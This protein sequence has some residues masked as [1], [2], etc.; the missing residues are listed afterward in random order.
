[1]QCLTEGGPD[2]GTDLNNGAF[3]ADGTAGTYTDSGGHGFYKNNSFS[4]NT[5]PQSN[6]F[7]HFGHSV[8]FGLSCKKYTSGPTKS[9]P[10]AGIP[11]L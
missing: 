9:P 8:T 6:R 3:P 10:T 11:T 7:H 4:D 1:M 5:A 2:G